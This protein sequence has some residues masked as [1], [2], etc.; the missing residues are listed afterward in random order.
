LF[1]MTSRSSPT[2]AATRV[3][4]PS[5][6]PEDEEHELRLE[7]PAVEAD[8][9]TVA[10]KVRSEQK[11]LSRRQIRDF[12]TDGASEGVVRMRI[13][14]HRD[15]RQTAPD[16]RIKADLGVGGGRYAKISP[17]ELRCPSTRLQAFQS[18]IWQ[19]GGP[20]N[21]PSVTATIGKVS[22]PSLPP[23]PALTA[24]PGAHSSAAVNQAESRMMSFASSKRTLFAPL[25]S[26]GAARRSTARLAIST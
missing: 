23:G 3:P 4:R 5:V 7:R 18:R 25:I 20:R 21:E 6:S 26:S 2:P 11:G 8:P 19:C 15:L 24:L 12:E 17:A 13:H 1:I 22:L 16:A 9:Q 14:R 10:G